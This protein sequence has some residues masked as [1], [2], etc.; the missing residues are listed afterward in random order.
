[1]QIKAKVGGNTTSGEFKA[2]AIFFNALAE[3]KES[4]LIPAA[5]QPATPVAVAVDKAV[6]T[7][8]PAPQVEVEQV[9][10]QPTPTTRRRRTKAEIEA[11]EAAKKPADP[12][13]ET[14]SGN[15]TVAKSGEEADTAIAVSEAAE[16]KNESV[17]TATGEI[18]GVEEF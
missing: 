2:L 10:P 5:I 4:E 16:V 8:Q 17:D 13:P 14:A 1:M 12:E 7:T 3:N 11:D 9:Q 18:K 15:S 6:E